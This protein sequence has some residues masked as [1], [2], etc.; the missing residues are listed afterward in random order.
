MIDT[1]TQKDKGLF[2]MTIGRDQAKD[3]G[4]AMVLICLILY[5]V[6]DSQKFVLAAALI[7]LTNMIW[8]SIF[9][10]LAKVWFGLASVMGTVVSKVILTVLF[11]VLVT[12]MGVIRRLSG[13]DSM[14]LK[15]WKKDNS[16]VFVVRDHTFETDELEKPY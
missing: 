3:T 12:P 10:P 7:L 4:M 11:F 15:N 8:P 5:F 13:S 1:I 14:Q 2:G 9:I 16:S 6:F